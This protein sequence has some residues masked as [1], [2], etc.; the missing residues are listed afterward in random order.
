[1]SDPLDFLH[2]SYSD[3]DSYRGPPS[4]GIRIPGPATA[5]GV[6]PNINDILLPGITAF[7]YLFP[8]RRVATPELQY[9]A[10]EALRTVTPPPR[11]TTLEIHF[12]DSPEGLA[13]SPLLALAHIAS[14]ARPASAPPISYNEDIE[15]LAPN[16]PASALAYP[17]P[18]NVAQPQ[19][20]ETPTEFTFGPPSR[21]ASPSYH[22][23]SPTPVSPLSRMPSPFSFS[24]TPEPSPRPLPRVPSPPP[25]SLENQENIRPPLAQI[26]A[27][28]LNPFLPPRCI[29]HPSPVHPH[30][31]FIVDL[32]YQQVWR[33]VAEGEVVS[34]LDFPTHEQLL[35][36]N[37]VF[38]TVTPFKGYSPHAA[39]ITP[40]NHWLAA[41]FD[42]P[43]L[44][45]CCHA[46]FALP[47]P[48]APLGYTI[49]TFRHSLKQTFLRHS[50]LV[51][52]VFNGAL[53]VSEVYDFLDGRRVFAYGRLEFGQDTVYITNQAFH[54]EDAVAR[55]PF[56]LRHCITPRVPADPCFFVQ[57]YPED[58][59]L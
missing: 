25:P 47:S 58:T 50:Q 51:R 57:V 56:L 9:P 34:F 7:D 48:G 30:Q 22:V 17:D 4:T 21:S 37:T 27:S 35:A 59:P 20:E 46:G 14:I 5:A 43:P 19:E 24:P 44:H 2:H 29:S 1:V 33:P 18:L 40:Q 8:P 42:I 15:I 28:T 52:N 6:L 12:V 54:F 13:L 38:P 53:V 49:Y 26:P 36:I 23:R 11:T 45:V 3:Y 32:D 10:E 39:Y 55:Y 41:Q 16:R 31:Y